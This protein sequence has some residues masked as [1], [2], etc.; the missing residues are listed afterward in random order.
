MG[1]NLVYLALQGHVRRGFTVLVLLLPPA[2]V[3]TI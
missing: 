3:T 1:V 2:A